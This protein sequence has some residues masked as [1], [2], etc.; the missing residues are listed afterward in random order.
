MQIAMTTKSST[1]PEI[2]ILELIDPAKCYEFF[3]EKKWPCGICCPKCTSNRVKK[4]GHKRNAPLCR[5]YKC[6]PYH[7]TCR[8]VYRQRLITL[9]NSKFGCKGMAKLLG[10]SRQTINEILRERR[11]I[12]PADILN[13]L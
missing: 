3:R 7:P 13:N 4:N 5:N 6:N 1:N 9:S 2:G 10:V 11:A 8:D 12:S